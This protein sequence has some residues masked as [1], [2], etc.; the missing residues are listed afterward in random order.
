MN[1]LGL[2]KPKQR[3]PAELARA[4]KDLLL[5]YCAQDPERPVPK[6]VRRP[7]CQSRAK[8]DKQQKIE[9]ELARSLSQIKHTFQGTAG[10]A[11]YPPSFRSA[12]LSCCSAWIFRIFC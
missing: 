10:M 12:A 4:T 3:S 7:N 8:A 6:V 5:K 1:F 9:E 2:G 11:A